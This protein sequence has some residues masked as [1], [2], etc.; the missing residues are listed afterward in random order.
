M[1]SWYFFHISRRSFDLKLQP[2]GVLLEAKLW[3]IFS[4][5][6]P[7][8][9]GNCMVNHKSRNWPVANKDLRAS[10]LHGGQPHVG[11]LDSKRDSLDC[12][13]SS[14]SLFSIFLILGSLFIHCL[15]SVMNNW[16]PCNSRTV[17]SCSCLEV[18]VG[19]PSVSG[20]EWVKN[21]LRHDAHLL[22]FLWS[23]NEICLRR[24][25]CPED[26]LKGCN[27]CFR[28]NV[29]LCV[30]VSETFPLC[31]LAP[32]LPWYTTL[33]NVLNH[34]FLWSHDTTCRPCTWIKQKDIGNK[35]C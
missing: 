30:Q 18:F 31:L 10:Q 29:H 23:R 20:C 13:D 2:A 19:G 16:K 26:M 17:C 24:Q 22:R 1:V 6:S 35:C 12:F 27:G 8:P 32:N 5:A 28:Q 25:L 33:Q 9:K 15:L 11:L 7:E 21:S 4:P 14:F 3:W 34:Y